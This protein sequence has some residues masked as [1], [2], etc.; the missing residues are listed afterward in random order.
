MKNITLLIGLFLLAGCAQRGGSQGE[1]FSVDSQRQVAMMSEQSNQMAAA[2]AI[3]ERL[4]T[5]SP[6][7]QTNL[8]LGRLYYKTGQWL[9]AQNHLEQV[10]AD[11]DEGKIS[12]IWLAK[13]H[14]KLANPEKALNYLP[15]R[16]QGNELMNLKAVTLDYLQRHDQAQQLYIALLETDK[17][18]IRA[19]RNLTYSLILS[20]K[21]AQAEQQLDLMYEL[22]VRDRQRDMLSAVVAILQQPDQT[23]I[24]TL[25][26]YSSPYE[27]EALVEQLQNIKD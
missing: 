10:A 26:G 20:G 23:A 24:R 1:A 21:Y 9:A 3:Y 7:A 16:V 22:G 6:D 25:E 4:H 2:L 14:L 8:D 12:R 17:L 18:D 5:L 27:V 19:R 15:D 13:T 11:S